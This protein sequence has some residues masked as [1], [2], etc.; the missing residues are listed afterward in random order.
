[1]TPLESIDYLDTLC[2]YRGVGTVDVEVVPFGGVKTTLITVVVAVLWFRI[3]GSPV[4]VDL[5]WL[6]AR[7]CW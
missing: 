5:F 2:G 3:R 4:V 1:M 7:S 6:H